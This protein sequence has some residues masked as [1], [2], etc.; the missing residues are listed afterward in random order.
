MVKSVQ[1]FLRNHIT[2]KNILTSYI[3]TPSIITT[4]A[5]ILAT[6][7]QHVSSIRTQIS[8]LGITTSALDGADLI[9]PPS[10]AKGQV[11]SV[12]HANGLPA[13]RTPGQVLYLAF[14]NQANATSGGFFPSG[15]NGSIVTSST[16][17]TAANLAT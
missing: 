2:I 10:G 9:P 5:R 1:I 17:A 15:V 12:N 3:T 8:V 4:A 14:G 13:T 11:L 6:E 16:P 7:S